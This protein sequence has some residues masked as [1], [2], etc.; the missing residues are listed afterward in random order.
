MTLSLA[1]MDGMIRDLKANTTRMRAVAGM[2]FSTATDLAD[3]LVR[4]LRVPSAP[5]ITS[6]AVWSE[7][8]SRKAAIWPICH[9]KRCNPSNRRSTPV[10][11]M[12]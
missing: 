7:W 6:P 10:F 11:S 4:E 1:A 2:G 12:S 3:W 9:W 5:P 8:P